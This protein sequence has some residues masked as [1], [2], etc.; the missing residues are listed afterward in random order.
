MHTTDWQHDNVRLHKRGGKYENGTMLKNYRATINNLYFRCRALTGIMIMHDSTNVEVGLRMAQ[1]LKADLRTSAMLK[2]CRVT[3]NNLF[4]RC[5]PLI[6]SIVMYN[7]TNVDA[8]MR[9]AHWFK[10]TEQQ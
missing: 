3:I 4:L 5:K 6:G 9:L 8:N 10:V 2:H 1:S 7:S